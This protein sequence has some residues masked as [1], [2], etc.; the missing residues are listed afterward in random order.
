[1]W[2]NQHLGKVWN[3][4]VV[5]PQLPKC[6]ESDHSFSDNQLQHTEFPSGLGFARL[7]DH[8]KCQYHP[9]MYSGSKKCPNVCMFFTKVD[10][11]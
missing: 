9:H 6:N 2:V 3:D 5:A 10:N 11:P 1:M 4:I 8:A 7:S